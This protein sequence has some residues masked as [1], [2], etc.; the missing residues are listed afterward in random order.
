MTLTRAT[1]FGLAAISWVAATALGSS[2][3]PPPPS[4][5]RNH[6]AIRY[7]ETPTQ[8]EIVRLNERL[9]RGEVQFT[10]EPT[11]GYLR[12]VLSAL[13][14]P[15][16]SQ[17]LVFAKTSFQAPR[18]NP[19]NPRAI[20]FNDTVAVG[21]VR[22]GEVLEFIAQDPRQGAI[23]Y[24]LDQR[25]TT[26]PQFVKNLGCVQCHTW[27][28]TS[29]V[30]GMF[31]SSIFPGP[32]GSMLYAPVFSVDHRTPFDLRWGG[33]YVTGRHALPRHMGN[34]TVAPGVNMDAMV[35]PATLNTTSLEGRFDP[36]GYLSTDSDIVALMVLEHQARMLNLL[37]RAGW[38]AR[39]G[40]DAGR[41]L[42]VIVNE[43]VDYLLFVDEEPLPSPIQG[44]SAFARTFAD[45]GAYDSRGRSLRELDLKTRLFRHPCSYLI[46]A[47]PFE[48]LPDV[49]KRAV[50]ARMWAILTGE[51]NDPKYARLTQADRNAVLEIL[52]ETKTDLP[53]YFGENPTSP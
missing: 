38:D 48:A 6:P 50:Y 14:V 28:A 8:D 3:G 24:A 34:A 29:S 27:E 43:L 26:T 30:P 13:K 45:I 20:Y 5:M 11:R 15:E 42:D 22:G 36:E 39:M 44:T 31:L 18:I 16:A 9:R 7:Q 19:T 40:A 10:F 53:A 2:Q 37:T 21:W 47:A 52:R 49:A 23:F 46:Y 25:E 51:L 33:W 12:S 35:T 41:P 17:V 4:M 1:A 32:D